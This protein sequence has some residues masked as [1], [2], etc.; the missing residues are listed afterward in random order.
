MKHEV[1]KLFSF[2]KGINLDIY[3]CTVFPHSLNSVITYLH[4]TPKKRWIED[5]ITNPSGPNIF[6][7]SKFPPDSPCIF[8]LLKPCSESM[9][10]ATGWQP[11]A[12]LGI[13]VLWNPPSTKF[14]AKCVLE[15]A[16]DNSF[17]LEEVW[18]WI[19]LDQSFLSFPNHKSTWPWG[20]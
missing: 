7:M 12:S 3:V 16:C 20:A 15:K 4:P 1:A 18:S 2:S 14:V 6:Q 5:T 8:F 10:K 11:H 19:I 13:P 17:L 9:S